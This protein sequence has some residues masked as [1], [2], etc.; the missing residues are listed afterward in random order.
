MIESIV[1]VI[2]PMYHD[3]VFFALL[4]ISYLIAATV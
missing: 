1:I 3:T 4:G 2:A